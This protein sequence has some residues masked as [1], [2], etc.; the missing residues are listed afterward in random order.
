MQKI[1]E[2]IILKWNFNKIKDRVFSVLFRIYLL[3]LQ[4]FALLFHHVI[5][6]PNAFSQS[7]QYGFALA[8]GIIP[9]LHNGHCLPSIALDLIRTS[10]APNPSLAINRHNFVHRIFL[11]HFFRVRNKHPLSNRFS[12]VKII[13]FI[14]SVL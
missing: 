11:N 5:I 4:S 13:W 1:V 7:G 2:H 10:K 3:S 8:N 6:S 14:C 9:S 12:K